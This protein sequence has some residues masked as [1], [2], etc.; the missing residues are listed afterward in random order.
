[1][2]LSLN[3]ISTHEESLT[4]F[5][6]ELGFDDVKHFIAFYESS[7]GQYKFNQNTNG[8]FDC[9]VYQI[10]SKFFDPRRRSDNQVIRAFDSIYSRYHIG[11]GFSERVIET[12]RNDKLNEDLARCLYNMRGIEQ[13]T[14][15]RKFKPFL[16]GY[17]LTRN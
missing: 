2:L 15:Y 4:R 5:N 6:R 3:P 11:K 13:W 17:S 7:N 16:T 8:S 14:A 9:G 1:V 12:L 10:N